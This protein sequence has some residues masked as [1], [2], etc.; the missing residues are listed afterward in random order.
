MTPR[1]LLIVLAFLTG[2]LAGPPLARASAEQRDVVEAAK[3]LRQALAI[4]EEEFSQALLR[5][6]KGVAI[7]PGVIK[8]GLVVG[9]KYG[10]GVLL[11]RGDDGEW[12]LPVII[13][14]LGGSF[15]WQAGAQ[16]TDL[17]LVFRTHKSVDGI[18]QGT[19]TVAA[20]AAVAAGPI[21]RQADAA[22]DSDLKAEIYAYSRTRGL[23]AGVSIEGA[24]IQP[25]P[26]A[27][28][29]YYGGESV[30]A[31]DVLAGRVRERPESAETLRSLLA[32]VTQK[33]P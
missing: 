3:V 7:I 24:G 29:V 19:F 6:A 9:G 28:A 33:K 15:G 1:A 10:R 17:I 25:D 31:S 14:L 20:E 11:V 16:S 18:A 23:F 21:G 27:N 12:S 13:K 8:L 32:E 5:K 2:F 4:P 26:S 30:S 22:T